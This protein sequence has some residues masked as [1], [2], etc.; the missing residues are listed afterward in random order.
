MPMKTAARSP[1]RADRYA[2]YERAVQ[3]PQLEL[4][5]LERMLRRAG[6]RAQ[7]L[8]EDF[9]G[10][11]LL[12]A[13]WVS[14]GPLRS[15]IAVDHDR[16]VHDWARAHRL[17]GLGPAAARLELVHADVRHGPEGPFDA[18]AALNFSYQAF[19]TRAALKDYLSAS[20]GALAPRGVLMLDVLGG[21]LVQQGLVERRPLPG[22]CATGGDTTGESGPCP[23]CPISSMRS[24]S[25]PSR[26]YGT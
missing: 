20:L 7:R 16:R 11:A 22:G 18:I 10:S 25:R 5:L 21:W 6:R 12:A 2:L 15:A 23:S 24:A 1:A 3:D 17:P 14:R 13:A 9:S 8:R 19:H 4:K 26:S